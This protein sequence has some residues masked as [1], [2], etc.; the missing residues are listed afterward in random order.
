MHLQVEG[1]V[2]TDDQGDEAQGSKLMPSWVLVKGLSFSYHNQETILFTIDPCSGN[3]TR[4][5]PS[6]QKEKD[7]LKVRMLYGPP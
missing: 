4:N 1:G 5:Q 7:I 3:L 2:A 6:Y